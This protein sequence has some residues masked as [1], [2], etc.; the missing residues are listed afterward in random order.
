M[1]IFL[2]LFFI[3]AEGKCVFLRHLSSCTFPDHFKILSNILHGDREKKILRMC[4]HNNIIRYIIITISLLARTVLAVLQ[5]N[6][7]GH[8]VE[9]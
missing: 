2:F 4:V 7:F 5:R 9:T 6:A 8:T 3:T 1:I